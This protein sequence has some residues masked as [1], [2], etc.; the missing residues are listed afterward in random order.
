MFANQFIFLF[1]QVPACT[2]KQTNYRTKQRI[3]ES[4]STRLFAF[5]FITLTCLYLVGATAL[6]QNSNVAAPTV[7]KGKV[8]D[9]NGAVI[10]GA[11]VIL[12]NLRTGLERVAVTNTDGHFKFADLGEDA[13]K[14]SVT[15]NGFA[16]TEQEVQ[17]N[18]SGEMTLKLE[19]A[20]VVAETT[21][22]SGSRQEEL[23]AGLNTKVEVI[24]RNQIQETGYQ[25][26]AEILRETPG[27]ITRRGS[28]TAGAAGEQIQGIDSRQVLVLIDGF[29]ILGARGIKR[30]VLNLDRQSTDRLERIE[31][32]KGASSAL[33]GSDAIGG[34]INMITREARQPFEFS[35]QSSAGNFGIV[36]SVAN[37]GFAKERVSGFFTVERHKNNGFD[38][39]P[40]TFDT[41]GAG[42]HRYD[43][44][45]KLKFQLADNFSVSTLINGYWNNVLG[46]AV[47]EEGNQ[48]NDI[49]EESQNYG[50]TADWQINPRTN[51][52]VRGYFGRF[53]EL[54]HGFLN[55]L[56]QTVLPDG[57]LFERYG[58]AE[59]TLSRV[60]GERQFI[61]VGTEWTTNR[62][63]GINRV[64]GDEGQKADTSTL[65][66]QDKISIVDRVTLT[67]GGRYDNHSIFG[68]AFSPK[69]GL[70]VRVVD[71]FNLR[72]SFGRGFRAPDLGQLYFLFRNPTNFYQV[73]GNPDLSPEH[74]GSWQAGGE[75]ISKNRSFR[76][77]AN[78]FRNDVRNLIDSVS[79]GFVTPATNLT[80][81]L[82]SNGVDPSLSQF[83]VRNR[84]LFV[85]KNLANIYTQGLELDGEVIL[86]KGVSL[87][88]AY[89]YLSARDR[90][91][92][93]ELFNRNNHHG[94]VRLNYDNPRH[95][96]RFNVRGTF[97]D[98]WI[99]A[100]SGTTE[101]I[102]RYFALWDIYASKKLK[103]GFEVFGAIDNFLD[104]RDPNTNKLNPQG[105]PEPI[106]RPEAGRTYR[107]GFKFTFDKE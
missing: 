58:K 63:R 3:M 62:Y 93:L 76:I 38:L 45:G 61:Q 67:V 91:T 21:V 4:L 104:S 13:F 105:A 89:T 103:K 64:R 90:T 86:P 101:T 81:L 26:V 53:D 28:E 40:T 96:F 10:H 54:T 55:N 102:G 27:V 88:A 30:G 51:L 68:D 50:V 5:F 29:P 92:G 73:L 23:R 52:Q 57:N 34:T 31:V 20:P 36:D 16:R 94:F 78:Y 12:K 80:T 60:L 49:D 66:F 85:Y 25:T 48:T 17:S 43:V 41:T 106:Y 8:V 6:A 22:Y 98:S 99:V 7:I 97:Y 9:K 2:T 47:G 95:G 18:D 19:P 100:R 107:I 33:F 74:S 46:R 72:A 11:T 59:I 35:F 42:F 14:L 39:T 24:T 83:V 70:N 1:K 15:A 65:W 32:V 71:G 56:Q 75:Y 84:L 44:F 37:L 79:L 77:G 87:A 82:S 69:V